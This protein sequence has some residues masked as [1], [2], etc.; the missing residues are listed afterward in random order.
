ME[1]RRLPA[2]FREKLVSL[3]RLE[4]ELATHSGLTPNWLVVA[5]LLA[6]LAIFSRNPSLFTNAQFYAED[7]SIWFANAYNH[8]WLHSLILPN[9]GYMS[10]M[11]RLGT[12]VALLT[13]FRF[14]PLV[15]ALIGL[16]VQALPVVILLSS[17]CRR[18]APLTTRAFLAAL[19][20]ALP[21]VH[22]I[23]VVLTNTMWHLALA[24]LLL[25]LATPPETTPGRISDIA[26]TLLA[27][28]S[29]PF[30]IILAPIAFAFW[31][32][33]RQ[34]WSLFL[35]A[36]LTFGAAVQ[37][38]TLTHFGSSRSAGVLGATPKLFL[39]ILAGNVFA[40]AIFGPFPFARMMPFA[41][42]VAGFLGGALILAYCLRSS[43]LE[44]KLV[45]LF[46]FALFLAE[47][48]NPIA[49]PGVPAWQSLVRPE[50]TRY[51]FFPM[52]AFVWASAW[53]A[54]YARARLFRLAG[55]FVMCLMCTGIAFDWEYFHFSDEH[56]PIYVQR[57]QDAAPGQHV[58]IPI[59]PAEWS[60][61]LTKHA[62]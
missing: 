48:H 62:P 25:A 56:F 54:L 35:T 55:V 2:R 14:A 16:L 58:I 4:A 1:P 52:L 6:I 13:P 17:R 5:F 59:V 40:S 18:L 8:G 51:S 7:G 30:S 26:I 61:D 10:T 9:V 49:Q 23:H 33:R 20:I 12:G 32:F 37:V 43:T 39:R 57:L 24:A 11:E 50:S 38:F 41:V 27:A 45:I 34:T 29:G 36:L 15:M 42:I 46:C 60:M 31:W 22:E 53:C 3:N 28:L 19:Y 47:L 44:L 21:N